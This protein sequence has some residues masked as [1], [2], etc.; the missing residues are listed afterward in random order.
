MLGL[1]KSLMQQQRYAQGLALIGEI[2]QQSPTHKELWSLKANAYLAMD[3]NEQAAMTCERAARIQGYESEALVLHA[4]I[5]VDRAR[6]T[7]A[8]ELLEASQTFRAQAHVQRYLEQVRRMA[9]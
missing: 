1:A 9:P 2:L 8:V 3:K 5:E 6:Y 7:R 4:Q